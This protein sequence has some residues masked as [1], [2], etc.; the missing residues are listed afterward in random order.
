MFCLAIV[1]C[2][3]VELIAFQESDSPVQH[4]SI[5]PAIRVR[6]PGTRRAKTRPLNDSIADV[7][8]NT[9]ITIILKEPKPI[10]TSAPIVMP[11]RYVNKRKAKFHPAPGAYPIYYAIA[12]ANG[13]F[14][15]NRI[16]SLSSPPFPQ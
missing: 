15:G 10:S 2:F 3:A 13:S 5:R 11:P 8:D 1:S 14:K 9:K 4:I 7:P 12:R 6:P 16:W